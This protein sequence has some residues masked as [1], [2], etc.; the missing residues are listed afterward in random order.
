MCRSFTPLSPNELSKGEEQ[1]MK[2]W[3]KNYHPER[4]R[5]VRTETTKDK[6][7]TLPTAVYSNANRNA[8]A[9]VFF[10]ADQVK[11]ML[12]ASSDKRSV[13]SDASASTA[14]FNQDRVVQSPIKLTQ[15]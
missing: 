9:R 10:P 12:T 11:Q 15:D 6:T 4:Q 13:V 8:T 2:D 3:L 5:T 14:D 1:T 7:G